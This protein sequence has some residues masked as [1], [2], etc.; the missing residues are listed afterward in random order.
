MSDSTDTP[1]PKNDEGVFAPG[2][3]TKAN[4]SQDTPSTCSPPCFGSIMYTTRVLMSALTGNLLPRTTPIRAQ[5]ALGVCRR[6][7]SAHKLD[8]PRDREAVRERDGLGAAVGAAGEQFERP[9]AVG[10]GEPLAAKGRHQPPRKAFRQQLAR[11]HRHRAGTDDRN[12]LPSSGSR[13]DR[14]WPPGLHQLE[15]QFEPA[16]G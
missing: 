4:I 15:R 11:R 8:G 16:V 6:E 1:F 3:K 12:R 7:F 10:L 9:A 14:A 13:H 2:Y 5:H